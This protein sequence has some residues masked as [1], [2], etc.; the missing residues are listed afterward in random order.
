LGVL[1]KL[2]ENGAKTEV[3][4]GGLLSKPKVDVETESGER[5]GLKYGAASMQGWRPSQ[6]DAHAAELLLNPHG[7]ALFAVYDGHGGGEVAKYAAKVL[8]EKLKDSEEYKKKDFVNA[9]RKTFLAVDRDILSNE[10]HEELMAICEAQDK[11][12]DSEDGHNNEGIPVDLAN[13]TPEQLFQFC[14][15]QG[16]PHKE[17][18]KIVAAQFGGGDDDDGD[19]DNDNNDDDASDNCGKKDDGE[20]KHGK[21][22]ANGEGSGVKGRRSARLTSAGHVDQAETS[23]G[24]KAQEVGK[25]KIVGGKNEGNG[26]G[27]G[28][29]KKEK[30]QEEEEE[31]ADEEEQ[32]ADEAEADDD[33]DEEQ[34]EDEDGIPGIDSGWNSS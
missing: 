21:D 14:Q 11:D 33:D 6:E 17:A 27:N 30:G 7:A 31:D 28:E 12:N 15:S 23:R 29:G 5:E 22:E 32:A 19:D 10:G 16:V 4:M 13:V 18:I 2:V 3:K 24:T 9:L 34:D 20:G 25:T 1:K 26:E 8:H